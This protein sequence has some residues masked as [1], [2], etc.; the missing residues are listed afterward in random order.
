MF[1][2]FSNNT[3]A[4][5]IASLQKTHNKAIQVVITASLNS[6]NPEKELNSTC[7]IFMKPFR[8]F[9]ANVAVPP[10]RVH[11]LRI[12]MSRR[13]RHISTEQQHSFQLLFLFFSRK[14]ALRVLNQRKYAELYYQPAKELVRCQTNLFLYTRLIALYLNLLVPSHQKIDQI[15]HLNPVS[16]ESSSSFSSNKKAKKDKDQTPHDD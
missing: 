16:D 10:P 11:A 12:C 3:K 7:K 8:I 15:E 14:S 6:S 9:R 5:C 13:R 1:L 2:N 4:V